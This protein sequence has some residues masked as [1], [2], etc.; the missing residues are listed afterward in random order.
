M[1]DKAKLEAERIAAEA[2]AALA[3]QTLADEAGK[4]LLL[5]FLFFGD[6]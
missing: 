3:A 5:F 6:F 4:Y 2:T 1:A